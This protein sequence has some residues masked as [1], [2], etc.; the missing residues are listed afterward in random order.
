MLTSLQLTPRDWKTIAR[1]A[2]WQ[3]TRMNL[4]TF[5]R[6]GVFEDPELVALLA[7]RLTDRMQIARARVLPYQLMAAF[8][9][10]DARVPNELADALQDAMET[11]VENIPTLAGKVYVFPDVSGSMRSPVTGHRKGA[12]TAIR[13]VDVAALIAAAVL[14][15]NPRAEVIAFEQNVVNLALNSRD[16]IMTNAGQLASVGGGGTN[17]S[18]PL[19]LLNERGATGDLVIYVS[20]YES[21]VDAGHGRG[22]ETLRQWSAFKQRNPQAR[23][24][25]ID[26]AP[27]Q[28]TQAQEAADIL[29]VGGFSDQVFEVISHF[30]AGTLNPAHWVGVIEAERL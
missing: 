11:A 19:A 9:N 10:R 20:D 3:T 28:T 18:A 13:C 7:Q 25:C 26:L 12:T 4:N 27:N 21:W 5:A 24:V 29:N 14:R 22:T 17:C 6:H 2:S 1:N 15:K 8:M 16:S 23:M 30:A